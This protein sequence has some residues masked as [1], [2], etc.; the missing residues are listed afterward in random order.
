LS[1]CV[2]TTNVFNEA[3]R[4]AET[5]SEAEGGGVLEALEYGYDAAGNM[6][7]KVDQ[8]LEQETSYAY[9]ALNR[10]TE[11][12][13]PGEGATAYG[14][15]AAGNRSEAG[16]TTYEYNALNQ[17]TESSDGTTYS[18]DGAGRMIG[19]EGESG[20]TAYEWDLL[21]HLAKVE[22]PGE[23]TSYAYDGL[24][25]LS[26]RKGEA[27]TQVTHYGD[28]TDI[29]TY[30]ANGEGKVTTSYIQGSRGL[31]EQRS[32]ETTSYPLADA[33]GD[34]TAITGLAGSVESR[35]S[36]DPWGVQLSGPSLEMG[37]LGAQERPTD[38]ATGLIQ[39]GTR[40]YTPSLG[41]FITEDPVMGHMG[42]GL[43]V[44]RFLYVWDNPLN[45]YDLN[46]RDVCVPTPFGSA[47]ADEGIEDVEDAGETALN[48]GEDAA[49]GIG[50][51]A[52][53]A[54]NWTAPGRE[55]IGD[56]AHDF[57]KQI[58][59]STNEFIADS[60]SIVIGYGICATAT[61]AATAVGT[62][63]AGA[64]AAGTCFT[65][66]AVTVGGTAVDVFDKENSLWPDSIH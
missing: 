22:G 57:V 45:R 58:N 31:T 8:R 53:H 54:W 24:E 1:R 17:L 44:D 46:G 21:D 38:S 26:E 12:N 48:A 65:S 36:Y 27:G 6:T 63:V 52:E 56:R 49:N 39:M 16:A 19:K 55:W 41:S 5:T 43:S 14:Y 47:C 42:V 37:Y 35:Q 11:F 33:H 3:G 7:S 28:L 4:L 40:S 20:K 18:Y 62:P 25:R 2:T 64:A 10:I 60:A 13:P 32:G 23:T 9:D 29:P 59:F 30:E 61:A 34:I 51:G 66:D 15:D 50:S